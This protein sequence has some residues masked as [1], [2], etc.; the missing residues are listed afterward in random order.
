VGGVLV[1]GILAMVLLTKLVGR[2]P[3]DTSQDVM[4]ARTRTELMPLDLPD[5]RTPAEEGSSEQGTK[6][7]GPIP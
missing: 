2:P 7:D 3:G 6:R 4:R 1:V 5:R